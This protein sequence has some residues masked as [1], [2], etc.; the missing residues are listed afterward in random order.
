MTQADSQLERVFKSMGEPSWWVLSALAANPEGLAP[1]QIVRHVQQVL[2]TADYPIKRLDPGTLHYALSRLEELGVI[3]SAGERDLNVPIGHGAM[4][5]EKRP[6]W[7]IT[8]LGGLALA[9]RARMQRAL[10]RPILR[11]GMGSI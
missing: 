6:V 1:F 4:R 9:R 8:A 3:E 2:R 7:A 11:P 5:T 10:A